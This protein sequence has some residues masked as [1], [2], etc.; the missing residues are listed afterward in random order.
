MCL[1][2]IVRLS[3]TSTEIELD[4]K[5]RSNPTHTLIIESQS[6]K[7]VEWEFPIYTIICFFTINFEKQAFFLSLLASWIFPLFLNLFQLEYEYIPKKEQF[8]NSMQGGDC[9]LSDLGMDNSKL[10]EMFQKASINFHLVIQKLWDKAF[11]VVF[12]TSIFGFDYFFLFHFHTFSI[13]QCW[14]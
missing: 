1:N 12:M 10:R 13:K 4:N 3:F 9:Q 7:H 2:S 8:W 6:S 5:T 14:S 11:I